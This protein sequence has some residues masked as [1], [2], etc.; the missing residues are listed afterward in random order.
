[1][2][3]PLKGIVP[4]NVTPVRP[5]QASKAD[6][7]ILVMAQPERSRLTHFATTFLSG[8]YIAFLGVLPRIEISL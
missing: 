2:L 7:S 1:L 4:S 8:M 5:I 6:A 3:N